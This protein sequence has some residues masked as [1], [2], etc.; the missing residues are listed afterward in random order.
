MNQNVVPA[1]KRVNINLY[2]ENK[3]YALQTDFHTKILLYYEYHKNI[4]FTYHYLVIYRFDMT[5]INEEFSFQIFFNGKR[6][7]TFAHRGSPQDIKTL[8]IDGDV[9]KLTSGFL[10]FSACWSFS[11][12]V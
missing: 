11:E 1:G 5:I 12:R 2:R 7:V 10:F 3:E 6:F 4:A 8:E 9:E